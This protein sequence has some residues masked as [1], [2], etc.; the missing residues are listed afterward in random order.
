MPEIFVYFCNNNNKLLFV[1]CYLTRFNLF[2]VNSFVTLIINKSPIGITKRHGHILKRV[3]NLKGKIT[4]S[5][6]DKNDF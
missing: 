4:N 2:T 6:E 1:Y 5:N 3:L